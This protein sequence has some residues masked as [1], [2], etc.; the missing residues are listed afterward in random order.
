[1][2]VLVG[3]Q[4]HHRKAFPN[5]CAIVHSFS[6]KP[7]ILILGLL[8]M[9]AP[10]HAQAGTAAQTAGELRDVYDNWRASMVR[11]NAGLWKRYT[12][13]TKQIKVRNRI[14]SERR[15]FPQTVFA[16]PIAP[17]D[18]GKLQGMR[19][20]AQGRTAKSTYFGK[21]DFGIGGE[22]TDN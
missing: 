15:P 11:K 1:M 20:R 7:L 18:I 5:V 16:S 13:T 22:P 12:S 14:W 19:V 9:A 2:V 21:V 17:P 10:A 3:N 6:M 4:S 8:T